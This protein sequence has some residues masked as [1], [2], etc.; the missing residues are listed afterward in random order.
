MNR[1]YFL[2]ILLFS[3]FNIHSALANDDKLQLE[4]RL[5]LLDAEAYVLA[6]EDL[7]NNH[8]VNPGQTSKYIQCQIAQR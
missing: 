4:K 3:V 1:N 8:L 2:F 6:I 7:A 5:R